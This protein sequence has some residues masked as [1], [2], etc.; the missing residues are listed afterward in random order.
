MSC[1]YRLYRY[2]R[3]VTGDYQNRDTALQRSHGAMTISAPLINH[4]PNASSPIQ[5]MVPSVIWSVLQSGLTSPNPI[6]RNRAA[7]GMVHMI[8]RSPMMGGIPP[9]TSDTIQALWTWVIETLLPDMRKDMS[10][11]QQLLAYADLHDRRWM[12]QMVQGAE[13]WVM[14]RIL[15][16][17]PPSLVPESAEYIKQQLHPNRP[18]TE[19]NDALDIIDFWLTHTPS[20][21]DQAISWISSYCMHPRQ[22]TVDHDVWIRGMGI[23]ARHCPHWLV[24]TCDLSALL[25][26]VW[27]DGDPNNPIILTFLKEIIHPLLMH[28]PITAVVIR[29]VWPTLDTVIT[30]ATDPDIVIAAAAT[31]ITAIQHIDD[32]S[33][34]EPIIMTCWRVITDPTADHHHLRI[35]MAMEMNRMLRWNTIAPILLVHLLTQLDQPPPSSGSVS[36]AAFDVV[37]LQAL[38]TPPWNETIVTSLLDLADAWIRRG[39]PAYRRAASVIL[40]YAWGHRAD[41][42]VYRHFCELIGS[43]DPANPDRLPL[44]LP[45]IFSPTVGAHICTILFSHA[46]TRAS[47]M[48]LK[49]L[50]NREQTTHS[51]HPYP[52]DPIPSAI[53]PFVVRACLDHPTE[54]P[55]SVIAYLW[56]VVPQDALS[57]IDRLFDEHLNVTAIRFL[58]MG[59]GYQMDDAIVNR[60]LTV[61]PTIT[62]ESEGSIG[63]ALIDAVVH[64]IDRGNPTAL[65]MIGATLTPAISPPYRSIL[66]SRIAQR[67]QDAP[68]V[69]ATMLDAIYPHITN[70][71]YASMID[72]WGHGWG[73]GWEDTILQRITTLVTTLTNDHIDVSS[74]IVLANSIASA[75]RTGGSRGWSTGTIPLMKSL[76]EWYADMAHRLSERDRDR[77]GTAC[78]DMILDG[79][80]DPAWRESL[81]QRLLT[82]ARSLDPDT[83]PDAELKRIVGWIGHTWVTRS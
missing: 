63:M 24:T 45:G 26:S 36:S 42:R 22:P 23:L 66:L 49:T 3:C 62:V 72:A 44:L 2:R 70:T 71:D 51:H 50:Q 13:S 43:S 67:W 57:V 9:L 14:R 11:V 1:T 5:P 21:R 74:R 29:S 12:W 28:P 46:P 20:L 79:V 38:L 6:I 55:A 25:R 16:Y 69:V 7:E 30:T 34:L 77:L 58:A 76:I 83:D 10:I 37:L 52:H 31:A 73:T 60:M 53:L 4:T 40:T 59:W 35:P 27:Q 18:R 32:P 48:I 65:A 54:T 75:I 81:A 82:I 78:I 68:T 8:S 56:H 64:G 19:Q 17:I 15:P 47:R 80:A 41:D 61:I 33:L 39:D